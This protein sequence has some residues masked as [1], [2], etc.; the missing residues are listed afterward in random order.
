VTDLSVI[1]VSY[2]TRALLRDCLASLV[3]GCRGCAIET[4][5]VDNASADGSADMVTAEFPAVRLIRN[6]QNAGFAAANN[7]ALREANARYVV[8]LNPD[9]VVHAG[10]LTA[11]VRFMDAHPAAG[12]CGPRLLNADGSHQVSAR[13]FPTLLSTA[14]TMLGLARRY[15]RSRH[16]SDL[17]AVYGDRQCIPAGWLTGACL[18]V[19]AETLRTV[20]LLDERFFMY[21]EETDWC[22]RLATAGWEGWYVPEAEVVHLGGRSVVREDDARPF[23]GDHPVHWVNSSRHYLRRHHGWAG[24]VVA[25]SLQMA[26]YAL[27]WLRH[28]WRRSERSRAK[29]RSAAASLSYLCAR[30]GRPAPRRA[31]VTG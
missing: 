25:E 10:A 1:I 22:R 23:F 16:A 11:L 20:G 9:T 27:I 6:P 24:L 30:A 13:R 12:Y 5:V 29:A 26:L 2:N 15:P 4:F 14:F 28:A 21:F 18:V 3:E 17:H 8:L 7:L 19:R 31:G